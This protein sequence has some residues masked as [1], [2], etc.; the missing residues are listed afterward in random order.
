MN[1]YL[2]LFGFIGIAVVFFYELFRKGFKNMNWP[3]VLLRY[4]AFGLVFLFVGI[5]FHGED[6]VQAILTL[7]GYGG[8]MFG[9]NWGAE[10]LT[11]KS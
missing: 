5:H 8:L 1:W 9:I 3:S 4:V 7:L 10:R 11:N 6:A 2:I